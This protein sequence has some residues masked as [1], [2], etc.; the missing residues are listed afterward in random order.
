MR[1]QTGLFNTL[2]VI[3][4]AAI[5]GGAVSLVT[6]LPTPSPTTH[7]PPLSIET[8]VRTKLFISTFNTVVLLALLSNYISVYRDIPNRFTLTLLLFTVALL[9]YAI[10]SSPLLPLILG[11][12]LGTALGPFVFLPDAFASIAIVVLLY[13]S[14]T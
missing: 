1:N 14:Y 4:L 7:T 9:L 13:Q 10:S 8:I 2:A 11:F 5:T 3:G 6:G 12:D